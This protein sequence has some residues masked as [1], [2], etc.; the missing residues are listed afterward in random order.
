MSIHFKKSLALALSAACAVSLLGACNGTTDETSG[1]S[2]AADKPEVAGL[3]TPGVLKVGM[4]IGYPPFEFYADDGATV[5]GVDYD[6]ATE[7]AKRLGLELQIENTAWDGIFAG[8]SAKKYDIITSA[9]TIT[10]ERQETMLFTS[11]YIEN[12]QAIVVTKGNKDSVT[13]V[14]DLDGKKVGY[15]NETTSDKYLGDLITTGELSCTV[16]EYEKVINCFDDLKLGRLNAVLCDSTVADGYVSREPDTFEIAWVQTRADGAEPETFGVAL[17]KNN[18][19]LHAAIE[20]VVVEMDKD[21]TLEKIR[22]E[23]F[24]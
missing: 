21:G 4:E 9:V 12:W 14:L 19:E 3:L 22:N 6:L 16:S 11:P 2:N 24:S 17:D 20:A 7:I 5:L 13:K 1:D 18:T 15:Q 10:P 23:W 8:L